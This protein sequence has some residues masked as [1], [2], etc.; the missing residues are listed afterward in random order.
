MRQLIKRLCSK[1][2]ESLFDF[3]IRNNSKRISRVSWQ[4]SANDEVKISFSSSAEVSYQRGLIRIQTRQATNY[5][6]F[7]FN[8][9]V[10]VGG[11]ARI[12]GSSARYTFD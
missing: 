3:I 5:A 4:V 10:L 1:E 8:H 2:S 6:R 11:E 9:H 12:V 7:D